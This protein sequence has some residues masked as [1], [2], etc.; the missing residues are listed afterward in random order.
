MSVE[1]VAMIAGVA[2]MHGRF[3]PWV[4]E[5]IVKGKDR[6]FQKH[7]EKSRQKWYGEQFNKR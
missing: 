3:H 6:A 4:S 1:I 7:L 5:Q 2:W